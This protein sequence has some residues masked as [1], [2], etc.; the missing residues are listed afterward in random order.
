VSCFVLSGL[1]C[2]SGVATLPPAGGTTV[3]SYTVTITGSASTGIAATSTTF[4][5]TIN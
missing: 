4:A 2:G 1:G 3:G 5:L